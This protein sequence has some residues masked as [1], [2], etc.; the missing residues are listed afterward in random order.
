MELTGVVLKEL[1]ELKEIYYEFS[2][3]VS[4]DTESLEKWDDEMFLLLALTVAKRTYEVKVEKIKQ[5]N[6]GHSLQ[7]AET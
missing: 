7:P 3:A 5:G 1:Q 4:V 6:S 2:K